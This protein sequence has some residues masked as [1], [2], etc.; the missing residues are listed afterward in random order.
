MPGSHASTAPFSLLSFLA[1]T[2]CLGDQRL[3]NRVLGMVEQSLGAAASSLA[4][5]FGKQDKN[6]KASQRLLSNR[7]VDV[8]GLRQALYAC[9]LENIRRY[10]VKTVVSVFDPTLLDFSSQ[11]W[12]P[13]RG[14]GPPKSPESPRTVGPP[15]DFEAVLRPSRQR[16]MARRA[17]PLVWHGGSRDRSSPTE[18]GFGC[19]RSVVASMF[20]RRGCRRRSAWP[21]GVRRG[22]RDALRSGRR[23]R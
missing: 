21:A 23:L 7:R 11:N 5:M 14:A 1:T 19:N 9:S 17:N 10:D 12:C 8:Q 18:G 16:V 4:A 6:V 3:D 20:F 13:Q 22:C 2:I 15:D